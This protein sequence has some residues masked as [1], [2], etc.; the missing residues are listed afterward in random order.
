[1]INRIRLEN[2]GKLKTL[3]WQNHASL[4]LLIGENGTGKTFL[5][6]TFSS[7][8][9]TLEEYKRGNE[10]RTAVEF[11]AEKLYWTFQPEKIGDLVSK[12]ADGALS[13]ICLPD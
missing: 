7:T 3:E 11:L 5:L 6:K 8:M 2:F 10:Q 12:W 1:M 13:C 4:N 9:R